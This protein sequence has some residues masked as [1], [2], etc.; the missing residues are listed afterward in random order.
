MQRKEQK[1]RRKQAIGRMTTDY[2][3]NVV[4]SLRIDVMPDLYNCNPLYDTAATVSHYVLGSLQSRFFPSTNAEP[5][6][7]TQPF[8][9][10]AQAEELNEQLS[11]SAEQIRVLWEQ[12]EPFKTDIRKKKEE[13]NA[14]QKPIASG[15]ASVDN[16]DK[17]SA[18]KNEIDDLKKKRS[19]LLKSED[20]KK[21]RGE[22]LEKIDTL[23]LERVELVAENIREHTTRRI[24][25]LFL[26]MIAVYKKNLVITKGKTIY[27]HGKGYH[28]TNT[29]GCHDSLYPALDFTA[30]GDNSMIGAVTSYWESAKSYLPSR[31]FSNTSDKPVSNSVGLLNNTYL[32]ELLN[33]TTEL[34]ASVNKFDMHMETRGFEKSSLVKVGIELLNQVSRGELNP[35]QG[36]NIFC[37][38]LHLFF[39][40]MNYTYIIPPPDYSTENKDRAPRTFARIWQYQKEGAYRIISS[41]HQ[42]KSSYIDMVLGLHKLTMAQ[43]TASFVYNGFIE[44]RMLEMQNELLAPFDVSEFIKNNKTKPVK[45]FGKK[46]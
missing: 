2:S 9:P 19:E 37:R 42:L 18:L 33:M 8:N 44:Q 11:E 21:N 16:T 1:G 15:N 32:Q 20:F 5:E 25:L 43:R 14:L 13:I 7:V 40:A 3:A 6:A 10:E 26:L 27:Q 4:P 23:E 41:S 39:E 17:I 24:E 38:N 22:L 34:P 12:A 29:A 28:H 35:I 46:T 45:K 36:M 30:P 31:F